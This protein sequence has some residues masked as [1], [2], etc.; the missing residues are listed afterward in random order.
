MSLIFATQ[1]TAAALAL[2]ALATAILA[3]MAWRKQSREVSDQA[4]MLE[5]QRRQLADQQTATAKQAEVLELQAAELRESLA[6]RKRE[7]KEKHSAQ[8]AQVTAW[9]GQQVRMNGTISGWGA[10]VRNASNLPVF[11]VRISFDWI[12]D[13]PGR[14]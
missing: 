11:D 3:F 8:A 10:M 13:Q 14:P 6:E 7:A 5:L 9:F 12:Y 4:E 2:A 1:L